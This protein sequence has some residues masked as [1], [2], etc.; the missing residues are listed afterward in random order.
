VQPCAI[1][2]DSAT[3]CSK[4]LRNKDL[5][6]IT[7]SHF[8]RVAGPV[9]AAVLASGIPAA[10]AQAPAPRPPELPVTR[11][12]GPEDPAMRAGSPEQPP[13]ALPV[14]Q[15]DDR[16]RSA[17]LD[18]P[19]L[20]SIS[21]VAPQPLPALLQLLVHGTPL[22]LVTDER[23]DG[24]FSGSLT[25]LTMRQ[26]IETV[27]FPRGLDYDV[28]GTVIRV[29][30]RKPE[31]RLYDVNYLSVRR[32]W[33]RS[34]RATASVGEDR[35]SSSLTSSVESDVL[36][37]LT[38]GVQALLSD[39][40]RLH[41]DRGAGL[42]PVTDFADRLDQV[43]VY[44]E[45]VQLRATRQIRID[46]RVFAVTLSDA[47]AASIDWSAV[48]AKVGGPLQGR[49]GGGSAGITAAD[50]DAVV[51]AIAEQGTIRMIAAPRSMALN[52]EPSFMRVGTEQAYFVDTRAGADARVST[53]RTVAEG[54]TL[55]VVAQVGPDGIVQLAIAPTYAERDGQARSAAGA[56]VPVLH[57]SEA[58]T[59]VRVRGGDTVIIAGFLRDRAT[60]S[61]SAG[62]A[63]FFGAQS[64][65]TTRSELVL[66]LTPTVV[67]PASITAA[68]AR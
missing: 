12:A 24:T 43:G 7:W 22:T 14:T 46:A 35:P 44:V 65:E 39:S 58:D 59:V 6:L 51:K 40:G 54:L 62:L 18:G 45:A 11:L 8:R 60:S 17:D 27:L 52:N 55:S 31:T 5:I 56:V 28:R 53:P 2:R 33:Q 49:P 36:D 47:S 61:P 38:R 29:F 67:T 9:A 50:P 34:V 68:A 15:L 37:E 30:P 23:V 3:S 13:A 41:V 1:S 42:V 10:R 19:R 63:G 21:L 16:A 25:N 4:L 48:A 32:A 64:H 20:V 66:L 26:A 57:V